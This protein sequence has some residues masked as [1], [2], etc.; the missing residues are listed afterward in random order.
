MYI[1][2]AAIYGCLLSLMNTFNP[3]LSLYYGDWASSVMIHAIGLAALLPLAFTWGKPTGSARWYQYLGG[4]IGILT[5]VFINIGVNG[6]GVTSNL[7]LMLL[8]QVVSS[9][10]VDHFGILGMKKVPI[11][12]GK[13][14]AIAVMTIACV[15]V[16]VFSGESL[17]NISWA[18]VIASFASGMTMVGSR[19]ANAGLAQRRGAGFSTIMN[20][21][22]G[23]A[24]SLVIFALMGFP[25]ATPDPG[26]VTGVWRILMYT[27]GILG[28]AGIFLS[29]VI[30]PRMPA[31]Q[32]TLLV[33]VGQVFSGMVLDA[34]LGKFSLGTLVGGLIIVAGMLINMRADRQRIREA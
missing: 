33:F 18:A 28:A 20:Y 29:N 10:V 25:V 11:N 17:Q 13:V 6:L 9:S 2:L 12:R 27:G 32:M 30:A 7:T 26:A 3:Q 34:L 23:L 16:V 5:V 21:V 22:T 8:G 15:V 24:G 1:V 14:L 19:L 4:L 31:L